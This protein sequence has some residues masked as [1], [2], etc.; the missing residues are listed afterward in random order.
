M[1]YEEGLSYVSG[2]Q[3]FIFASSRES[4][5]TETTLPAGEV[6]QCHNNAFVL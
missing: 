1:D 4:F 6:M 5:L 2:S 3:I